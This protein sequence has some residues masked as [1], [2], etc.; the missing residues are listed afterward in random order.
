VTGFLRFVAILNA[1]VWC[2][3]AIFLT[4]ALPALFTPEMKRLLTDVGVGYAAESIVSRFFILQ[5]YCGAIALMHLLVEWFY[6]S[7]PV[8]RLNFA[9]VL[10]VL[11]L[12][13]VG[14]L[15]V[16]PKM[17]ALHVA[18]YFGNTREQQVQAGKVFALWHGASETV[19][20]AAIGGLIWYLWRV[21]REKDPQ[22]FV[23]LSKIRG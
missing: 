22:R 6:Y 2:G 12:G 21:S 13:I 4:I 8:W 5:Y 14:G 1:A 17:R 16:Q 18:K 9:L 19:N 20:L 10:V 11:T 23:S 3:S 7:R 15:W